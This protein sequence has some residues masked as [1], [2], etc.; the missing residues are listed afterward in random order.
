ME[1]PSPHI[2]LREYSRGVI[3]VALRNRCTLNIDIARIRPPYKS[4]W[5]KN[6]PT[7]E[8]LEKYGE[9]HGSLPDEEWTRVHLYDSVLGFVTLPGTSSEPIQV[10]SSGRRG[11]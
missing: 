8:E 2:L 7:K 10:R 4:Q 11:N 1:I 6:I 3:E 5:P 9:H